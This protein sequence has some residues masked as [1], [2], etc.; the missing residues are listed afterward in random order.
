MDNVVNLAEV[1]KER[2]RLR[3][4]KRVL[5]EALTVNEPLVGSSLR[6]LRDLGFSIE[7]SELIE[8]LPRSE[9]KKDLDLWHAS[10]RREFIDYIDRGS[11]PE[12]LWE[13]VASTI[14]LY[15]RIYIDNTAYKPDGI[16]IDPEKMSIYGKR[17]FPI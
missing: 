12:K 5:D 16:T 14:G 8:G 7:E 4:S 6:H 9:S 13:I 3:K 1:R 10:Q 15:R 17:K 2:E 11:S